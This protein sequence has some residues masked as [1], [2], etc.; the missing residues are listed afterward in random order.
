[1]SRSE[2][3]A[4][5][6]VR[7]WLEEGV[8]ALPDHVLD[9][10]IDQLPATSQR[11]SSW[12]V[13]R[14]T[15]VNKFVAFG[16]AA[17]AV[18]VAAFL[19][20]QFLFGTNVGGPPP[21]PSVSPSVEPSATPEPTPD[22]TPTSFDSHPG[23]AL[24]PGAYVLTN[25]EPFQ[26]T[27]TVP[28][29]WEKNQP[30]AIVWS[31]EDDKSTITFGT[32]DDLVNDPCDPSQG[33]AAIGPTADDLVTGLAAVPGFAAISSEETTISGFP[34]AMVD[35]DW[36][37]AG[38]P[39]EVEAMLGVRQPGDEPVLHPGGSDNL[40]DRWYFIDVDGDRLV[41]TTAAHANAT[42]Q[43]IA[44]IQSILDSIQIE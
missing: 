19:G 18:V 14:S 9:A 15:T 1:M 34:A 22:S 28:A 7:L 8:T 32:I 5:R 43:R 16:L 12:L 31:R 20:Y 23:G 27:F 25:V 10:V 6:I 37:E 40:F 39:A 41:I 21:A 30:P 26:I 17:A 42:D 29:G 2:P 4:N 35:V 13:R 24:T 36:T 33:Y 3:D 11:R 44:D 38:C